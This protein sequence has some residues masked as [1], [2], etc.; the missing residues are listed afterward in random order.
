M[1][2]VSIQLY[3]LNHQ[4]YLKIKQFRYKKKQAMNKQI[5]FLS[6]LIGLTGQC[7]LAQSNCGIIYVSP[8]GTIG[9]GTGTQSTPTTLQNALDS[10]VA[11]DI[12]RLATGTYNLDSSIYLKDS[13]TLEGGYDAIT[14]TKT[15]IAGA[16]NLLRSSANPEGGIYDRRLVC[17]YGNGITNFRLQDL[18]LRTVDANLYSQ[19]TY[20]LHLT[21]CSNYHIIRTQILPGNGRI[22][23]S[24]AAGVN[25]GDGLAGGAGGA[26]ADNIDNITRYSGAGG[27]S[28]RT[29]T[30]GASV[31]TSGRTT[32]AIG[33]TG[34]ISS[35]Y[36]SGGSGGS[37]GTGGAEDRDGGRGGYGGG[38]RSGGGFT[39][40]GTNTSVGGCPGGKTTGTW[41]GDATGCN[42]TVSRSDRE[43]GR[44]GANGR[45]GG[46]GGNGTIG[47]AGMIA[48]GF[49]R[50]G[51]FGGWGRTGQGGQGG[52]GGGGGAGEGGFWCTDGTGASGGGGGGGA[53]GG[54]GGR[55]GNGGG[56]SF[57][58]IGINSASGTISQCNILAG[59]P[60][61]GGRGGRGGNGG[62]GGRGGNGGSSGA[63]RDVGYGG[64]GGSGGS[65][66]RGGY[67]G[68]GRPGLN[69]NTYGALP[70]Y[71]NFSLSAQPVIT[72]TLMDCT[73]SSL[74]YG[75]TAVADWNL[76][77]RTMPN[78]ATAVT[79]TTRYDT[80]GRF[81]VR[82][83]GHFYEGFT[84]ILHERPSIPNAGSDIYL[85]ATTGNL[86][87]ASPLSGNAK[88]QSLGNASVSDT[89]NRQSA[90]SSLTQGINRFVW[91]NQSNCCGERSDTIDIHVELVEPSNGILL[92]SQS[93]SCGDTAT[94]I[95]SG[96]S[97]GTNH[98]TWTFNNATPNQASG[99]NLTGPYTIVFD[100]AGN[101][102]VN[103]DILYHNSS[104]LYKDSLDINI[105]CI[106]LP[107]ELVHFEGIVQHN[108]VKLFWTT[109]MEHNND[110]F[111][112]WRKTKDGKFEY[113]SQIK[114]KAYNGNSNQLIQYS[115]TEE[116]PIYSGLLS[117][118]LIQQDFN[119]TR[120][121][122][123]IIHI[124]MEQ[125]QGNLYPNP[126]TDQL[127][128]NNPRKTSRIEFINMDGKIA[129]TI[130]NPKRTIAT[131][132]LEVGV[133]L[134]RTYNGNQI[135]TE[136]F[137]KVSH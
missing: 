16:T 61:T 46:N 66:G 55:G 15:S 96:I 58:L 103:L 95:S 11:G 60:G 91:L 7:L 116:T 24:G 10:S 38:V 45:N 63:G 49:F 74:T 113:V 102:K 86:N 122:S 5:L 114:S 132:Q 137:M 115:F 34:S 35:I 127:T 59:R 97:S 71:T 130:D 67:G 30:G 17:M 29:T 52:S 54:T 87:A 8:T 47:S 120:E 1:K 68:Y 62:R 65:G 89:F 112:V 27:R 32:G 109:S 2:I 107:V 101:Q 43:S 72:A 77:S 133:Y 33:R 119:G 21:N 79:I 93:T 117:Y 25:G 41:G 126:F 80:T 51:G 69:F 20:G 3:K 135:K 118:K 13:I 9:I 70:P 124:E 84:A 106:S 90:I 37:G 6:L 121:A 123:K 4:V 23:T 64:N 19:S 136:R 128:L 26:G 28:C 31:R 104:C 81:N 48:S 36:S 111:E 131:H 56:G 78:A 134:I 44:C 42:G 50:P 100:S 108:A 57:G 88:W 92:R 105:S 99:N 125:T 18:T 129:L 82:R 85:C 12:L 22:G 98:F 75:A 73:D 110:F 83:G 76:S 40:I 53:C 94:L 14:W 39:A